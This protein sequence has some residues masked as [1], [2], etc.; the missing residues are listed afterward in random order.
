MTPSTSW[1]TTASSREEKTLPP[2]E[3]KT[4][5]PVPAIN[6]APT[7]PP[8]DSPSN[9]VT[10]PTAYDPSETLEQHVANL[11]HQVERVVKKPGAPL[12]S[13]PFHTAST[14]AP[15]APGAEVLIVITSPY[16]YGVETHDGQHGWLMREELDP[17]P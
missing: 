1:S 2:S 13:A 15:L 3:E 10:E 7:G 9:E 14:L 12:K 16:W 5:E 11:R 8:D 17:L 4:K 6:T